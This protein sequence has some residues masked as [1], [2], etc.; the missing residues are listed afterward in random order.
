[1]IKSSTPVW[2]LIFA[3]IF[4]LEYPNAQLISIIVVIVIGV[5]L[6]V[7]G[8]TQLDLFGFVLVLGASVVSGLR[9]SLTQMLL[10]EGDLGMDNPI[11]TLYW[12]SPIMFG[13]MMMMSLLLESIVGQFG[14]VGGRFEDFGIGLETLGLMLLGGLLGV[15]FSL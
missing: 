10:Q 13:V 3:F 7:A 8:E 11:A 5:I 2:V 14:I 1:M 12:L 9:W 4:R 6:T 15:T